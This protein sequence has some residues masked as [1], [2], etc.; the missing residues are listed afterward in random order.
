MMARHR[1]STTKNHYILP[2][3]LL[4]RFAWIALAFSALPSL[5]L[6]PKRYVRD[7]D[8]N[9][10]LFLFGGNSNRKKNDHETSLVVLSEP[11]KENSN[12]ITYYDD[13]IS[14]LEKEVL[15]TTQEKMD[16]E[17]VRRALNSILMED[18]SPTNNVAP[19]W[20]IALASGAFSGCLLFLISQNMLLS[21]IA[22][23]GVF[24]LANK[25][26]LAGEDPAGAMARTVST[27]IA[28]Q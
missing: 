15:A 13:D 11:S 12:S 2:F 10:A 24:L 28:L 7:H 8:I 23:T 20:S 3:L 4:F 9:S 1:E 26:P 21:V 16:Q 14:L 18:Q 17:S 19:Q 5:Q 6:F 25:D 22:S 27:C